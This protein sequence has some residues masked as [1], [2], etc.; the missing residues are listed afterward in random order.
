MGSG[1][2]RCWSCCSITIHWFKWLGKNNPIFIPFGQL[3]YVSLPE[4][5]LWQLMFIIQAADSES[6]L[7]W[8]RLSD[9]CQGWICFTCL[10]VF[11]DT[12]W[13]WCLLSCWRTGSPWFSVEL[14]CVCCDIVFLFT[15]TGHLH[16]FWWIKGPQHCFQSTY[17]NTIHLDSQ[18]TLVSSNVFL[19]VNPVTDIDWHLL[20]SCRCFFVVNT[21]VLMFE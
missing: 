5:S 2:Y 11:A 12:M 15:D 10:C 19:E 3:S 7:L 21:S 13:Y 8:V 1:G 16:F 9:I 17:L 14:C 4:G 6:Q 20:H 18:N